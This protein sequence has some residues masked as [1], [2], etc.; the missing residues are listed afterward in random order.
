M[1]EIPHT[2][3]RPDISLVICTLDEAASIGRVLGG[4]RAALSGRKFEIIIVDDSADEATGD[5]V[6][7]IA[8]DD[9]RIRL[10]RRRH[11]YGLASAA[12]AGWDAARGDLLAIMDGDGQHDPQVV[13]RLVAQIGEA[14][15]AVGSRYLAGAQTG[16]SGLRQVISQAGTLASRAL[17]GA[18]VTDPLSGLFVMRRDWYLAARPRL[19]GIGFK[20]LAD[21]LACGPRRPTVV[22]TP[23]RLG[24]RIGGDSKLDLRVM[25]ELAGQLAQARTRGLIPARFVMFAI[26]GATGVLSHMLALLALTLA[27]APFWAAQ[28][29]AVAVAMTGNFFLNNALT[30]RDLR[31]SGVAMWQGLVGFYLACA[32]GGLISE[33]AGTGMARAG[34]PWMV[35]GL[36]GA[37]CAA[38][39]NYWSASRAAWGHPPAAARSSRAFSQ[40]VPV[41]IGTPRA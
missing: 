33:I 12:I 19:S 24:T 31:L 13:A 34:A 16:L 1:F 37:V 29:G 22:E 14:D 30:F 17:I 41:R 25:A 7:G 11:G 28:L 5:V 2:L 36:A 38:V 26:V 40:A 6:R 18:A 9:S 32:G 15:V 23:T 10:I 35:A 27:G 8:L 20:I 39:W 3:G 4:A 21:I